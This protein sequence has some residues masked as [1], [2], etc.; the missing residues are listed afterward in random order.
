MLP[1]MNAVEAM[2]MAKRRI[3]FWAAA[4]LAWVAVP[5]V[6]AQSISTG[7]VTITSMGCGMEG[8]T[9]CWVYISGPNVGPA[10][11]NTNSIRWDPASSPN[12]QV[13]LAQLTAAYLA[14]HTVNFVLAD[15]CWAKWAA[16]PTIWYYSIQ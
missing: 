6:G 7:A 15:T 12:G 5:P 8:T 9:V 10:G 14:G 2:S 11:C 1:F 16:Y 4:A 3:A 13:A